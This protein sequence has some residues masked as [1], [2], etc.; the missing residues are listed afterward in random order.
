MVVS[1]I[2]LGT[3]ERLRLGPE[4]ADDQR[5]ERERKTDGDEDLLEGTS[6]ERDG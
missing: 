1:I 3:S 2:Q 5:P 4:D 6:I